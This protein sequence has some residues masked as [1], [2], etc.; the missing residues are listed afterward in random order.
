MAE[1]GHDQG[2]LLAHLADVHAAGLP[3]D[4]GLRAAAEMT[5]DRRL[6]RV[7][8]LAAD[9]VAR[10]QSLDAALAAQ[11][12]PGDVRSVLCAAARSGRP[13]D[14]LL[15]VLEQRELAR[16][17]QGIV[18]NALAYPL[19]LLVLALLLFVGV[20]FTIVPMAQQ[21]VRDYQL[22]LPP[23]TRLVFWW[24]DT[25][26]WMVLAMLLGLLM[27]L[28]IAR[29]V[30]GPAGWQRLRVSAPLV[31]FL[32]GG[33]GCAQYLRLLGV[34]LQYALPLPEALRLA[35]LSSRD[36]WIQAEAE[37]V[38]C[39]VDRGEPLSAGLLAWPLLPAT[40]LPYVRWGEQQQALAEGLA[41]AGDMLAGE[42]MIRA[43]MLR[44]VVPPLIL[45]VV[46]LFVL[47]TLLMVALPLYSLMSFGL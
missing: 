13:A 5:H 35:G 40:V 22:K 47:S 29:Y 36:A 7:L 43:A 15:A 16:A 45:I 26:V 24:A 23:G 42:V 11:R 20:M 31:G 12:V 6:A 10:G 4:V 3:L 46:V 19:L 8:R 38:A 39:V 18:W 14:V 32:W 27:A 30:L 37:R 44:A 28:V 41:A 2:E 33:L 21:I 9:A 17:V 34:M 1:F 25:G